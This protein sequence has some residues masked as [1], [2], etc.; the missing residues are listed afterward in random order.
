ML[1]TKKKLVVFLKANAQWKAFIPWK[2]LYIDWR[3]G[4]PSDCNT[5]EDIVR[6]IISRTVNFRLPPTSFSQRFRYLYHEANKG[7]PDRG[8]SLSQAH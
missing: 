8:Y 4:G 5:A 3:W 6:K 7:E 1:P 2:A